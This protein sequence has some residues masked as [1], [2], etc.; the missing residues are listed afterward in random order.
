MQRL[1]FRC[2]V[3]FRECIQ[4]IFKHI[5]LVVISNIFYFHPYFGEDFQFDVHIFQMGWFNHQPVVHFARIG[6]RHA[7]ISQTAESMGRDFFPRT[8]LPM[9]QFDVHTSGALQLNKVMDVWFGFFEMP[10]EG[11]TQRNDQKKIERVIKKDQ[12]VCVKIQEIFPTKKC[13]QV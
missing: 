6:F 10:N 3:N 13:V 9:D 11:G 1:I 7:T 8:F 5:V 12:N 2:Y 4:P